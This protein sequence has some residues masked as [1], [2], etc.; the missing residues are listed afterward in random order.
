ML[1][2]LKLWQRVICFIVLTVAMAK[3][4]VWLCMDN[5]EIAFLSSDSRAEWIVYPFISQAGM[6]PAGKVEVNFKHELFLRDKPLHVNLVMRA[7]QHVDLAING[8]LAKISSTSN[9]KQFSYTDVS[10]LLHA[11]NNLIEAT[12]FNSNGPPALWLALTVDGRNLRSDASWQTHYAGLPWRTAMLVTASKKFGHKTPMADMENTTNALSRIWPIWMVLIGFALII[13]VVGQWY[14]EQRTCSGSAMHG[15]FLIKVVWWLLALV[16]MLWILL[17]FNNTRLI[18]KHI[19]FDASDHLEYINYIEKKHTLPLPNEGWEMY[20]PPLFY[21]FSAVILSAFG[22]TV[23]DPGSCTVL[24]FDAMLFGMAQFI[25]VFMAMQILFQNQLAPQLVAFILAAFLPMNL[26]MSHFVTNEMMAATLA[27]AALFLCFRILKSEKLS[28]VDYLWLGLFLGLA[29][30]TKITSFLAAP[31]IFVALADKLWGQRSS[32]AS[33][34]RMVGIMLLTCLVVSGWYYAWIW[35]Q[36]GSPYIGNW[37]ARSGFHLWQDNGY[38]IADD[39]MRFGRSLVNPMFSGING[40]WDGIYSTLWGDGLCSGTLGDTSSPPW[41]YNLMCA[42]YILAI[43]PSLLVIVGLVVSVWRY[44]IQPTPHL[45]VFLGLSGTVLAALVYMNLKV[46][47]YGESKAFYGSCALMPFCY[48]GAI[49]W[50]ALAHKRKYMQLIIGTWLLVWAV[51]SFMSFWIFTN[52]IAT[53]LAQP[54]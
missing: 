49:G 9:W 23:D 27:T 31:F 21:S 28:I 26:Y 41:N 11:S 20:Q 53:H 46:P 34:S 37:D 39:F 54:A 44:I 3:F 25:I 6:Y 2:K 33:F 43:V 47:S 42:G 18:P 14:F 38:H 51:N 36:F 22:L 45:F 24:R 15:K 13:C 19:G 52:H 16:C 29:T 5:P 32:I 17:F 35:I 4:F 7:N 8:Q 12:V 50:E 40:F 10:C 1:L 48:F 30:L